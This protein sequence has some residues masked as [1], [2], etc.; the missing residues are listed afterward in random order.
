MSITA[1][2]QN[3]MVA[4][5]A[6][7]IGRDQTSLSADNATTYEN[8]IKQW[9][10]WSHLTIARIYAFPELD[11]TPL[12]T[13][14]TANNHT[15]TFT[16]LGISR[17]RQILGVTLVDGT[18]SRKLRQKLWRQFE[19]DYPSPTDDPASWPVF[20]TIYGRRLELYPVPDSAYTLRV[21]INQY[22]TDFASGTSTSV[23]ENKDDVIVAGAVVHAY[24]SLQ[25]NT[26]AAA[27]APTFAARLQGVIGP[28][29]DPQDWEPEG[30]AF[31]FN[32][33]RPVPNFHANPLVFFNQ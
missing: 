7:I 18:S 4:E 29:R 5:V 11:L 16:S 6:N 32:T 27:W 12:D 26:D 21:R 33:Q 2:T 13:T 25:E 22:P 15:Y 30:R 14:L 1:M 19:E 9:L 10:F 24:I 8:R 31:D 20:Y 23:Y 28:E 3:E 17:I